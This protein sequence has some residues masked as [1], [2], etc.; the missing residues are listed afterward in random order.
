[1]QSCIIEESVHA[2]EHACM[3]SRERACMHRMLH[4]GG[5]INMHHLNSCM[6]WSVATGS[7]HFF[8]ATGVPFHRPR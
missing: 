2:G 1:M 7:N 8:M 6:S 4:R 3:L 5:H